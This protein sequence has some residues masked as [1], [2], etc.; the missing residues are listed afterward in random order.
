MVLKRYT[1]PTCTLEITAKSSPLS[2][3][4]GQ[5]VFKSLNFELRLDDPRLPDTEHVTLRGD[6]LQLE[7]LHQAVSS[8]VQNLLGASRDW[9][10][11]LNSKT[12]LTA[13]GPDLSEAAPGAVILDRP[14]NTSELAT[15]APNTSYLPVPPRL[16]PRGWLAHNLFLG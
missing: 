7:T 5:P 13:A 2:R 3:W 6:R 16:E 4:A 8:Y 1:P 10:S 9:E 15:S 14:A 11:N 12:D